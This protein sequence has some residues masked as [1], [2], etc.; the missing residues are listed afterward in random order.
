MLDITHSLEMCLHFIWTPSISGGGLPLSF[1][2][3]LLDLVGWG[4][5]T[6]LQAC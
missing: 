6:A 1:S 2:D 4:Q 3:F 5:G